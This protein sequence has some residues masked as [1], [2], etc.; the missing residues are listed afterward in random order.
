MG[1]RPVIAVSAGFPAYGDY[2]GLAYAAP[3]EAVGALPVHL[4]YLRDPAAILEIAGGVVLGFGSD[5]HPARYGGTPH[6]SMTPHSA[7]RDAFELE[8]A[9]AALDRGL[10]VLGICRGM[11]LLNVALGGTLVQHLPDDLGHCDHRRQLGSFD[12][13]DHDVRLAPGSLAASACGELLHSTKSHHHQ[14]V[15]ELGEGLVASGWS[16]LDDLVEAVEAPDARWALGVQWHPEVD[17]RSGVI[18]ALVGAAAESEHGRRS[19]AAA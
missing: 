11:Q 19:A 14:G 13:A 2:M 7:H 18:A 3:L 6:A 9:R 12:N 4:P 15:D 17:P 10:P 8:L 5:I 16:V 1:R